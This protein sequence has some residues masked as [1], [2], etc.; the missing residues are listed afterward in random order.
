MAR[1]LRPGQFYSHVTAAQLHGLYLPRRLEVVPLLHVTALR[2]A[3]APRAGGLVGHHAA[4]GTVRVLVLNGI[5]VASAL[6]TWCALASDLTIPELVEMGDGLVRRVRPF[7]SMDQLADAV[8]RSAGRRGS[9]KLRAAFARVR[10]G[11]DSRQETRLRLLIVNAGLPEPLVNYEIRDR[12]GRFL[13]LGDL[14][15]PK[16]KILL[17]YDGAYHFAT[18][19]QGH[20]DVD[21]LDL[22]MAEGWRVIRVHRQHMTGGA[23]GRIRVIRQALLR[24]GWTPAR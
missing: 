11:T 21:R 16:W 12:L 22:V 13:A 6:D 1:R 5:P 15:Y 3:T 2:P 4:P 10:P 7:A 23:S 19:A 24:A 20:H 14:V 9:R 18:E 8:L 17:E